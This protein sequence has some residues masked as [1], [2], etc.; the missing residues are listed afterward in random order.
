MITAIRK[1]IK[2]LPKAELRMPILEV[3]GKY[4]SPLDILREAERG[5]RIGLLAQR[6]LEV[7]S[8]LSGLP[9]ERLIEERLRLFLKRYPPDKPLFI[10]LSRTYTPRQILREIELKTEVGLHWIETEKKYLE[11]LRGL[12]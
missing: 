4:L 6:M 10:T 7:S 8:P 9:I 3:E 5:S 2:R 1:W 11:Y 12:L